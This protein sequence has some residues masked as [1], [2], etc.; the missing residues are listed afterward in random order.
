MLCKANTQEQ[1]KGTCPYVLVKG[2][3]SQVSDKAAM[4]PPALVLELCSQTLSQL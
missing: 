1:T 3:A 4:V 2:F